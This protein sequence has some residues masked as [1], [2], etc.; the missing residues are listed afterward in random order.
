M[1]E[2]EVASLL[3]EAQHRAESVGALDQ[4]MRGMQANQVGALGELVG[5]RLLR[6]REVS[7]TEVYCVGYDV[8]FIDNGVSRTMEF[9]TK[10]RTVA[11]LEHYDC[12]IPLYNHEVQR[13]DY[14]FFISLLSSGK[15]DDIRRFTKAYILGVITLGELE[16][17]GK[18]WTPQQVDESNNWRPTIDCL[19]VKVSDLTSLG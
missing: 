6:E 16:S 11:P 5:I 10:E 14:Y 19:N 8:E 1:I 2:V 13:P 9:K 3:D 18:R 12:T 7:F 17:I 4:S 15:S